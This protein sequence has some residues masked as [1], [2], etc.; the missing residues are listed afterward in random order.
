MDINRS[1]Y[2]KWYKR[3]TVIKLDTGEVFS[4]NYAHKI[5]KYLGIK[6]R[7]KHYRRYGKK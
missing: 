3:K 7:S 2:Y 6:S 4:D 1:G 5:C